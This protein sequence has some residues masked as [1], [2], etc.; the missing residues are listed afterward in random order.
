MH[1]VEQLQAA[2]PQFRGSIRRSRV[3]TLAAVIA[4]G[5]DA[6]RSLVITTATESESDYHLCHIVEVAPKALMD[7]GVS[8]YPS[9]ELR[10]EKWARLERVVTAFLAGAS[11]DHLIEVAAGRDL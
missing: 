1:T 8:E 10:P 7:R 11:V 2:L 3:M 4:V 5:P 6:A 9:E